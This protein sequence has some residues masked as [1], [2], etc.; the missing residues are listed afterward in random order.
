MNNIKFKKL[1]TKYSIELGETTHS[2]VNFYIQKETSTQI[3]VIETREV[4]TL[5]E[6]IHKN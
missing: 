2:N 3:T 4:I 6:E 5:L 1:E